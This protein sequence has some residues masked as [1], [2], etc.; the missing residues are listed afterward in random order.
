VCFLAHQ[1]SA[2]LKMTMRA[3]LGKYVRFRTKQVAS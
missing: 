1:G 2:G 3:G